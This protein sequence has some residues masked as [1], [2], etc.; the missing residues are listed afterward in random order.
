MTRLTYC[1]VTPLIF[2]EAIWVKRHIESSG[3]QRVGM[4]AGV[5]EATEPPGRV[6]GALSAKGLGWR[7]ANRNVSVRRK[8]LEKI[9]LYFN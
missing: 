3:G 1:L 6:T 4:V 2:V 9:E 8:A 5:E 7:G